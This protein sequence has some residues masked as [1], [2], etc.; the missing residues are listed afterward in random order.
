MKVRYLIFASLPVVALIAWLLWPGEG[1]APPPPPEK[2]RAVEPLV[3]E[4]PADPLKKIVQDSEKLRPLHEKMKP[5]QPGDWLT[6]HK[7]PGQTFFEYIA[8]QPVVPRGERSVLYIQPLGEFTRRQRKIVM[9]AAEFMGIYFNLRVRMLADLPLSEIPA[10]ARRVHP[11]WGDKQILTGYVLAKVLKPR[12]PKDAAAYIALTSSDL[13]PGE[14]WN[15]VFGMASLHERVGVWSIYRF[16]DPDRE[17]ELCLLRTL[18][19][20]THETGHMFSIE[21]CT[22]YECNMCGCNSQGESDRR[23]LALC[24]EDVAK[25]WW[26][27]EADPV[28]RYTKL[29]DFCRRENLKA[30]AAFYEKS[31]QVLKSR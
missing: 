13:W 15:F 20:A 31:L 22:A 29:R 14:G 27:T 6:R 19:I 1:S 24:P 7:E 26:G 25:V 2:P 18:K 4:P 5:P 21:H 23:P 8:N 9:L 30:E 12:L 3:L 11:M 17:Y 28:E 10:R 16:G